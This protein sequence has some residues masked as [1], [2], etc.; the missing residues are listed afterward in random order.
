M[1]KV[2]PVLLVSS[3]VC[4]ATV[5]A[6]EPKTVAKCSISSDLDGSGKFDDLLGQF[7]VRR[8]E[9]SDP[10]LNGYEEG[11]LQVDAYDGGHSNVAKRTT[12]VEMRVE[13]NPSEDFYTV[14]AWGMTRNRSA[15]AK[16]SVKT[17]VLPL[18]IDMQI[19]SSENE[20]KSAQT[21]TA[22]QVLGIV[23]LQCIPL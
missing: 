11:D 5:M 6:K 20:K 23:R 14:E 12:S 9:S 1:K 10:D 13:K 18:S 19:A 22:Q 8:Y 3:L 2:L 4:S 17:K 16:V 15:E 7:D 21:A